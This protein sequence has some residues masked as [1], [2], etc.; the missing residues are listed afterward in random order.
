[1]PPCT[2]IRNRTRWPSGAS[3]E[4]P[5]LPANQVHEVVEGR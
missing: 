2:W 5:P 3:V 1:M 4:L